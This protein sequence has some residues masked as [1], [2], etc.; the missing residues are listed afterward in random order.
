MIS[1]Q[2]PPESSSVQRVTISNVIF[3]IQLDWSVRESAWY[4]TLMDVQRNHLVSGRKLQFGTSPTSRYT[5]PTLGGNIYIRQAKDTL[6]DLG[7]DNFG[8]D[9]DYQLVWVS[10]EEESELG[11]V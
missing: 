1:F 5:L 6:N 10:T 4:F 9:S 11:L 3:Y 8:Q 2:I 7:R